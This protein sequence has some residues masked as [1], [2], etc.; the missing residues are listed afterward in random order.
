MTAK[1]SWSRGGA[2]PYVG[3]TIIGRDVKSTP[4]AVQLFEEVLSLEIAHSSSLSFLAFLGN[5]LPRIF[6][7]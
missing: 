5:E 6:I 1:P 3:T 4:W 7:I 2:L